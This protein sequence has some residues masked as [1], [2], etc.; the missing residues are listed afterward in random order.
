MQLM[1]TFLVHTRVQFTVAKPKI[2]LKTKITAKIAPLVIINN[3]SPRSQKNH[4]ILS[5]LAKKH[6]L[7]PNWVYITAIGQRVITNSHIA[8]NRTIHLYFLDVNFQLLDIYHF[9]LWPEE[10]TTFFWFRTYLG[11]FCSF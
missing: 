4:R 11:P 7:G 8:Y 3:V 1:F 2:L 6:F 5:S 10:T 9:R